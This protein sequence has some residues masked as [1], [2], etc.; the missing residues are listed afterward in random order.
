MEANVLVVKLIYID[1]V[2]K[3]LPQQLQDISIDKY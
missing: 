1:G 2:L 3:A